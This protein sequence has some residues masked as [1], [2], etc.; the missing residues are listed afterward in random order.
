MTVS[1]SLLFV[2]LALPQS[3]A[4]SRAES[5]AVLRQLDLRGK[6]RFEVPPVP[7]PALHL[8]RRFVD[9]LGRVWISTWDT[10][11]IHVFEADGNALFSCAPEPEDDLRY[12]PYGWFELTPEGH[13]IAGA[14][15]RLVEFDARGWRIA[16]SVQ[17]KQVPRFLHALRGKDCWEV[18]ERQIALVPAGQPRCVLKE[19]RDEFRTFLPAAVAPDG[20]LAVCE[21]SE[22]S[23]FGPRA[24]GPTLHLF[25]PDGTLLV[26]SDLPDEGSV[27]DLAIDGRDVTLLAH[28]GPEGGCGLMPLAP[29]WE[30]W[31]VHAGGALVDRARLP[32][33]LPEVWQ[34]FLSP[35]GEELWVFASTEPELYRFARPGK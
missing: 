2:A 30:I 32:A 11:A 26:S 13:L 3:S 14:P 27:L 5:E 12:R 6:V 19:P 15:E 1:S 10:A 31:T 24:A 21:R 18:S 34:V 25:A 23:A 20:A 35:D 7:E 17:P 4:E 22:Q 28:L 9:R 29:P 8:G 33:E 16:C